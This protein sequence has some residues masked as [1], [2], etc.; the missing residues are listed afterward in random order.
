MANPFVSS[1]SVDE[2]VQ[3]RKSAWEYPACKPSE[4]GLTGVEVKVLKSDTA[5]NEETEDPKSKALA[6]IN[7]K[8][9]VFTGI[10]EDG[11]PKTEQVLV[12]GMFLRQTEGNEPFLQMPGHWWE[13]SPDNRI[14]VRNFI[15]T[16]EQQAFLVRFAYNEVQKSLVV[17]ETAI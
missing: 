2:N 12:R 17:E 10:N 11:T 3:T 7:A 14:F 5:L 4:V 13:R 15:L 8:L 1:E 16:E 9:L 6:S